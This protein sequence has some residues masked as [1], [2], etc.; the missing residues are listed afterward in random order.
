MNIQGALLQ[1][2]SNLNRRCTKY[3]CGSEEIVVLDITIFRF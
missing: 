3:D 1:E 2:S